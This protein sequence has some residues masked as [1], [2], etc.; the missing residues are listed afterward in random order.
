LGVT[1]P[2][3]LAAAR[4]APLGIDY[5]CLHILH[6]ACAHSIEL[7]C[8]TEARRIGAGLLILKNIFGPGFASF[9]TAWIAF[10]GCRIH[11]LNRRI[12]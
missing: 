6:H 1:I 3:W 4:A 5:R 8:E 11:I 10:A 7:R 12:P 2:A 9:C